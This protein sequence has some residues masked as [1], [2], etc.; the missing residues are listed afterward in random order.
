MMVTG[1]NLNKNNNTNQSNDQGWHTS[2]NAVTK[3]PVPKL[4]AGAILAEFIR[5]PSGAENNNLNH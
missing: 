3:P 1:Q 2:I 4:E 5:N